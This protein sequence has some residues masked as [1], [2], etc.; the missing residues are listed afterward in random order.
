MEHVDLHGSVADVRPFLARSGMLAVP[1]RIGGG[2]RLKILEALATGLPVVTTRV[3]V[4]GLSLEDGRH[5]A[6]ADGADGM[7]DA[8]LKAMANPG[9]MRELAAAGRQRVLERYDWD[10]LALRLE[11]A[12]LDVK[13]VSP[14]VT[15]EPAASGTG[16]S[17]GVSYS[18][19]R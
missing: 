5:L 17:A 9:R 6:V 12:W 18:S 10:A 16:Q 14:R 8:I 13:G 2:S 4:E 1:L 15:S 11:R 19:S 3:G 7:A